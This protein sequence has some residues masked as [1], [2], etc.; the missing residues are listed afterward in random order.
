MNLELIRRLKQMI[1]DCD[2]ID[3][4]EFIRSRIYKQS[5]NRGLSVAQA[6]NLL[7]LLELKERENNEG[8]ESG[9][10]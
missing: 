5:E 2:S 8:F 3:T 10:F 6:E 9:S 4:V 7:K 1:S